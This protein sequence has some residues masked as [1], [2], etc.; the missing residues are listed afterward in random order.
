MKLRHLVIG[1]ILVVITIGAVAALQLLRS[2]LTPDAPYT[3]A[4]AH[5]A[6]GTPAAQQTPALNTALLSDDADTVAAIRVSD[7]SVSYV[8]S[9]T[10][11]GWQLAEP[12][13]ADVDQTMV[14][15]TVY[16]LIH[17]RGTV[18]EAVTEAQRAALAEPRFQILY[19]MS[20]GREQV[21][22]L[23]QMTGR[24]TDCLAMWR[25]EETVWQLGGSFDLMCRKSYDFLNRRLISIPVEA[26][27][28]VQISRPADGLE[29]EAVRITSPERLHAVRDSLQTASEPTNSPEGAV[30]EFPAETL[31]IE[32]TAERNTSNDFNTGY[33]PTISGSAPES[34]SEIRSVSDPRAGSKSFVSSA[35]TSVFLPSDSSTEMVPPAYFELKTSAQPADWQLIRPIDFHGNSYN[36]SALIQ[37]AASLNAVRF[38]GLGDHNLALYG[39]DEPRLSYVLQ[40]LDTT[41]T[42]QT[43]RILLG[44]RL[45]NETVYG[46]SS[47]LDAIFICNAG[48]FRLGETPLLDLI[49]R[50]PVRVPLQGIRTMDIQTPL[51][52]A[53]V[54]IQPDPSETVGANAGVRYWYNGVPA[55]WTDAAG[56]S[57]VRQLYRSVAGIRIAGLDVEAPSEVDIDYRI[58]LYLHSD[59]DSE[60]DPLVLELQNRSEDTLYIFMNGR[61]TGAYCSRQVLIED[62]VGNYGMLLALK[63]LDTRLNR[64]TEE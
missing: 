6:D 16:S 30:P 61:Y 57:L 46:Y 37:E 53:V 29:L 15:Q 41:G 28:A 27:S 5:S 25:D 8:L 3:A 22:H 13:L 7:G 23:I 21:L 1:I 18:Q 63:Q 4:A 54:S 24:W 17:L 59:G 43:E 52:E 62:E 33:R 50:F 64:V 11:E 36:L 35:G 56:R 40:G 55:D 9:R 20:D 48:S 32:E 51:G 60:A 14:N 34:D 26:I 49:D 42:L 10:G 38:V 58:V 45:V 39:L 19:R 44:N 12:Q 31:E 47:R 2:G